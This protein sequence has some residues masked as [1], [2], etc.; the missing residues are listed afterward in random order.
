M[1]PQQPLD[2][3]QEEPQAILAPEREHLV[4]VRVQQPEA[5]HTPQAEAVHGEAILFQLV[6]PVSV[7]HD[8]A[9]VLPR[10][11]GVLDDFL[12]AAIVVRVD[13]VEEGRAEEAAEEL[14]AYLRGRV[15]LLTAAADRLEEA[16]RRKE[17]EDE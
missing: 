3:A 5:R 16:I 13:A 2:L 10:E 8:P 15:E 11:P 12:H 14:V 1:L 7:A 6:L 17:G 4:A 9:G